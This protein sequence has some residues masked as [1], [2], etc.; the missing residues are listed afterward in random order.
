M[1]RGML[2]HPIWLA[3]LLTVIVA[4]LRFPPQPQ[5]PR[6]RTAAACG[7]GATLARKHAL[8]SEIVLVLLRQNK[9]EDTTT[10]EDIRQAIETL[11]REAGDERFRSEHFHTDLY[12]STAPS[13]YHHA[14]DRPADPVRPV[15]YCAIPL[16]DKTHFRAVLNDGSFASLPD[17]P[18]SDN[19]WSLAHPRQE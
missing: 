6:Q 12:I 17:P 4:A 18:P 14:P 10:S 19:Y 15:I 13:D 1:R 11:R 5:Q 3:L 9:L 16:A 8:R 2:V 7:E